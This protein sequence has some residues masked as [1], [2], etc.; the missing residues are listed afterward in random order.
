M[1][2]RPV[3]RD[4]AASG[5]SL[6]DLP[7]YRVGMLALILGLLGWNLWNYFHLPPSYPYDRYGNLIV[8]LM[9]L[10]NHLAF[11]FRWPPVPKRIL[12][13]L[14]IGWLGFGLLYVFRLSA[15]WFPR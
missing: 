3:P 5:R 15:L 9:L 1:S 10:L 8:V 4:E 6:F 11:S 12:T 2:S 14:A 13:V 7:A